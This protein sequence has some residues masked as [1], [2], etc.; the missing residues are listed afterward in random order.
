MKRHKTKK[1]ET[2]MKPEET[3]VSGAWHFIVPGTFWGMLV[4]VCVGITIYSN[5]LDCSFHLDDESITKNHLITDVKYIPELIKDEPQ[6]F[7]AYLTFMANYLSHG[8]DVKGYHVVNIAIHILNAA[9][10]FMIVS[11]LIGF[12]E[13]KDRYLKG[14][15]Y[16]LALL[17]A[18]LFVVHPVQTQAVTY[19][20]QRLASLATLFYLLSLWCYLMVR[21]KAERGLVQKILFTA[22]GLISF[23]LGMFTKEIVY[24]LPILILVIEF[25]FVYEGK[26]MR[27]LKAIKWFALIGAVLGGWV[28][29][30]FDLSSILAPKITPDFVEITSGEYFLTQLRVMFSYMRILFIP[31]NLNVDHQVVVAKSLWEMRIIGSLIGLITIGVF[32]AWLSRRNVLAAFGI[33][34]FFVAISIESTFIPLEDVMFEH[35]LYLPMVGF[36]LFVGCFLAQLLNS[37]GQVHGRPVPKWCVVILLLMIVIIFSVM[38]HQRNKAWKTN[39]SLWSDAVKKSPN[40]A[41]PYFNLGNAYK[42]DGKYET[43]I[44]YYTKSIALAPRYGGAFH[45][46]GIA[47]RHLGDNEAALTDFNQAIMVEPKVQFMLNRAET[48]RRMGD[49][50]AAITGYTRIISLASHRYEAFLDRGTIY[51]E[52]NKLD[53]AIEDFTKAIALNPY[54]PLIP[55]N[56]ALAYMKKGEVDLAFKDLD[57]TLSL[58]RHNVQALYIRGTIHRER[59]EF[60]KAVDDYTNAIRINPM[61]LEAINDRGIVYAQ[62]A[63]FKEAIKDFDKV[64]KL[65]P[66]YEQAYR[67]R[68][69]AYGRSGQ[70]EKAE[71]D[72]KKAQDLMFK[73]MS[74]QPEVRKAVEESQEA[75]IIPAK[76][77]I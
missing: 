66:D 60:N 37:R 36:G 57:R 49:I 61:H 29:L 30:R 4:I 15:K 71:A 67:N 75:I 18:G 32:T 59:Q 27:F 9:L 7:V 6:R 62:L 56:R 17:V 19:V 70:I 68:G 10:I 21:M 24:T 41:R 39:I 58:N 14:N 23:V 52:M 44:D 1:K 77:G 12:R 42:R 20:V 35:R 38:S 43:S 45:A 11:L 47:H 76:E 53:E 8:L 33:V 69:I 64:L 50:E 34:W 73:N 51:F 65:N 48:L 40:K 46:R 74:M 31:I 72:I 16:A 3:R 22:V 54:D 25:I 2:Q 55:N 5:S 26:V 63:K 28:L 13:Q